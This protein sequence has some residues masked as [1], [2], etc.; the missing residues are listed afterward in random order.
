MHIFKKMQL[1]AATV[2]QMKPSQVIRRGAKWAGL[3]CSLGCKV[4]FSNNVFPIPPLYILDL[5]PVFLSRF[6]TE[7]LMHD[8]FT[9]L[10]RTCLL[11][12]ENRWENPDETP[13]WNFNLHYFEFLFPLWN[14]YLRA[15]DERYLKQ[16]DRLI[17]CWIRQNPSARKGPGWEAYTIALRLTNWIGFYGM[18][19]HELSI[20]SKSVMIHSMHEQYDYLSRHLEKDILGNHYFENLKAL[21]LCSVFFRDEKMLYRSVKELRQECKEEIL[22]DGMHYELSPMY[23]N[24]ILEGL[25]KVTSALR[26]YG[27]ADRELESYLQPMLDAAWSLEESASRLP[28]FNDTG[29]NVAK[30]IETL[31]SAAYS[32]FGIEP[33]FKKQL[34]NAGYYIYKRGPWKLIID[35]GQPGPSY[36]PGHAHCDALSFEL[37]QNGVPAVVNCGT[38]AYQTKLR[39]FFRSTPAHNTVMIN[40]KEQSH[41]W[42]IFRLAERS[43]VHILMSDDM[44]LIAIMKDQ[45]GQMVKRSFFFG[46][47]LIITDETKV[48]QLTG[49]F[50]P[51]ISL[52]YSL[53]CDNASEC[54]HL[55]APEYGDYSEIKAIKYEGPGE[56]SLR[57]Y[58]DDR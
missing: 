45:A 32:Y 35:A 14:A 41:C 37:F 51:M 50:H 43:S 27:Q 23:H 49:F 4:C 56:I 34:P 8:T 19:E 2:T 17:D 33:H 42:G 53:N 46:D 52:E 54:A 28:L 39:D 26:E 18:A 12:P 10:H 47:E 9:F 1:Y 36:I 13:L 7:E 29:N 20:S 22:E 48:G 16:A 57:I 11:N 6:S 58:L 40:Q 38:Y 21:V 5:D 24:L 44:H 30:G 31:V 15:Q 3:Q 55:Y 25:L